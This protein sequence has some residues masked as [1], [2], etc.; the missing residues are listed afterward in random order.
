[1]SL[2]LKDTIAAL[3]TPVGQSGIAIVR[4]SG[5]KS[6]EI[7]LRLGRL[8]KG[9]LVSHEAKLMKLWRLSGKLLDQ[10]LVIYMQAPRSFTGEDVLEIQ[11]HGNMLLVKEILAACYACGARAAEAGEFSLRAF[12]NGKI[13]LVQAE[14][15]QSLIHAKSER[16]LQAARLQ[17]EGRLSSLISQFQKQLTRQ[18]AI[19]EA[20]VDFPEEDLEFASF[21]EMDRSLEKT[22]IQMRRLLDTYHDGHIVEEGIALC[23]LGRP[24]VGKSSLMNALLKKERSIVT[25]IAGTTRDVIEERATLLGEHY[26]LIDTAGLREASEIIEKEGIRRSWL[27]A[28]EADLV[29]WVLDSQAGFLDE[30]YELLEK[31]PKDKTIVIWNKSDIKNRD[32]DHSK[33]DNKLRLKGFERIC[34]VSA[35][36]QTGLEELQSLIQQTIWHKG[37]PESDAILLT[38]LRHKKALQDACDSIDRVREGLKHSLSAEFICSDMRRALVALSTIIGRD[39]TEDIIDALFSTFCLGK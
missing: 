9:S 12:K 22:L 20:W 14:S 10:A 33:I 16:A 15:V 2:K 27:K 3:S 36:A 11:C 17:L 19:L 13:D 26:R 30:D 38:S 29:L 1:M 18:A 35:V 31:I 6:S 32:I 34:E 8:E 7:V 37:P 5:P 24:N 23:L 28:Q 25:N 4:L 21:E 39:V